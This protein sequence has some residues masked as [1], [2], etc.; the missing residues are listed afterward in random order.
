MNAVRATSTLAVLAALAAGAAPARASEADAFED[1]VQP[2]SGRLYRKAGRFEI[3]PSVSLSFLDP[4][5][6]KVSAGAKIGYHLSERWSVH[7]SFGYHWASPTGSTTLCRAGQGCAP[8]TEAQLWQ[9]PGEIEM[10]A[11]AEVGFSLLYGKLN[12]VAEQVLH[13][14]FSVLAGA[15]WIRY[16]EVLAGAAV[17]GGARPGTASSPG[18]HLGLGTRIFVTRSVALRAEAKWY[19][20][21]ADVG[22]LGSA[23]FQNQFLAELGISLFLPGPGSRP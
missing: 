13:F 4:F 6:S 21:R 20:Y 16:R 2:V 9:V 12:L 8:A 7:A 19:V 11:G 10:T 3:G 5:F 1:K 17:E 15:D 18:G 22:N 14:D 23:Q